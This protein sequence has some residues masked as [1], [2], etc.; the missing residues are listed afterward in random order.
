M[1]NESIK[2]VFFISNLSVDMGD[3]SFRTG[4]YE[5]FLMPLS[6]NIKKAYDVKSKDCV[7]FI[8]EHT[9]SFLKKENKKKMLECNRVERVDIFNDENSFLNGDD[10]LVKDYNS[11]NGYFEKAKNFV[12][13]RLG[14]WCPDIIFS[15]EY[16]VNFLRKIYPQALVIDLMPG[17]FMRPPFPRTLSVDTNGLYKDSFFKDKNRFSD[18][19]LEDEKLSEFYE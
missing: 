15:W 11:E 6:D 13:G 14:N 18:R 19:F 4:A 3:P 12:L 9:F 2:K 16:P 17:P 1:K 5:K 7:F 10:F 8:G